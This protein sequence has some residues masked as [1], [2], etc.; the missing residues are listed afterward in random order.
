M[1][2]LLVDGWVEKED[3][4]YMVNGLDGLVIGE[5]GLTSVVGRIG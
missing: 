4:W 3:G 2:G 5:G 1:D